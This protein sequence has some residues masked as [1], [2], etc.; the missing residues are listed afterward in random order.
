MTN[1]RG[2]KLRTERQTVITENEF[3]KAI[4]KAAQTKDAFLR[5][6]PMLSCAFYD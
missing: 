2:L 6:R 5:H 1:V 4:K 3:N